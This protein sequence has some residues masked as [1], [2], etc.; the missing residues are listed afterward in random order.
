LAGQ[1]PYLG[2]Q[3]DSCYA[4]QR[5]CYALSEPPQRSC[6]AKYSHAKRPPL[7]RPKGVARTD[8]GQTG[9]KGNWLRTQKLEAAPFLASGLLP[10]RNR[11]SGCHPKV[12]HRFLRLNYRAS[13]PKVPAS[14]TGIYRC[15]LLY[16]DRLNGYRTLPHNSSRIARQSGQW[17]NQESTSGSRSLR[18]RRSPP[19]PDGPA[20]HWGPAPTG[21]PARFR[22]TESPGQKKAEQN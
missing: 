2:I 15:N 5:R 22:S 10:V 21:T 13:A 19:T 7:C 20:R 17:I 12:S 3:A 4:A 1:S 11:A 18:R 8:G 14:Q 6:P 16:L 9:S